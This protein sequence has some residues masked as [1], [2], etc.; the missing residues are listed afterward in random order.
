MHHV[1]FDI[2]G[3][4]VESFKFDEKCYLDAVYRALGQKIDSDWSKYEHV[5][6]SGI[7]D[8]HLELNELLHRREEIHSDVKAFFIENVRR[9]IAKHSVKSVAGAIDFI[10]RL[11]LLPSVSVSIATGGWYETARMKLLSA[12]FDISGIPLSSSNDHYSRI[13]IMKAALSKSNLSCGE[14]ITYFGDA[15]WDKKACETLNI[16]FVLIGSR[17][18][19]NQSITDFT[20]YDEARTYIGL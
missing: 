15:E 10:K 19:H 14:K 8:R 1:M 20:F 17:T 4:L 3:T 9:H 13:E 16:N 11:K 12:G 6:D 18:E 2:D 7:L 5:T